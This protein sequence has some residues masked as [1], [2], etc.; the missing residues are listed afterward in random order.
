MVPAA[1]VHVGEVGEKRRPSD[2]WNE[3][4]PA[5]DLRPNSIEK[6]WLEF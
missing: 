1:R 6:F 5:D 3:E 2:L 4:R